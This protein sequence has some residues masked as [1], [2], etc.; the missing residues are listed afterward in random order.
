[1]DRFF[2]VLQTTASCCKQSKIGLGPD[3]VWCSTGHC[4]WSLVGFLCTLMISQEALILKLGSFRMT[5]FATEKLR[6]QR[7]H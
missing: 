7:T 1:M 4:P 2:S 3:F 5:V 6:I